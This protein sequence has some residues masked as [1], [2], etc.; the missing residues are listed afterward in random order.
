[1]DCRELDGRFDFVVS[2]GMLKHV[3]GSHCSVFAKV[4]DLLGD[5]GVALRYSIG[6]AHGP[7][8]TALFVRTYMVPSGYIPA[9]PEVL[10]AIER[11][12]LRVADLEILRLHLDR[13][14]ESLE[15]AEAEHRAGEGEG[16]KVDVVTSLAA[17]DQAYPSGSGRL[18][19]S[20][21]R[22]HPVGH[23]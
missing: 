21:G 8:V 1:M 3:G 22:R 16:G 15:E 20:A 10:P 5:D 12:G 2:V 4:R 11:A 7:Y 13:L 23:G 9:L 18:P 6:R 14:T 17:D 19:L